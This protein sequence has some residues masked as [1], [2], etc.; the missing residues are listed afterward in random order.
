MDLFSIGKM[1]KKHKSYR[2]A[3]LITKI[4]FVMLFLCSTEVFAYSVDSQNATAAVIIKGTVRD[5]TGPLPGISVKVKGTSKIAVTDIDGKFSISAEPTETLAFTSVGYITK[6]VQNNNKTTINVFLEEDSQKLDELVVVGYGKQKKVSVTGAI[7]TIDKTQ[8]LQSPQANISNALVGRMPGLLSVQGSGQPGADGSTL[9]I[10]GIG[11]FSGNQDPLIMVDGIETDNYNNID[12]NEIESVSILKDASATAVYGVRGANGVLIITTRRGVEGKP[13]VSYSFQKAITN[14][15]ST[16]HNMMG[17]D[18]ARNYNEAQK[19]DGYRTGG[20]NPYFTPEAI[21]HYRVGDDPVFYPNVDWFPYMFDKTA[22]QNQHNFNINGGTERVKYFI[23]LGYFNQEGL[24]NH[25]DL[26]DGY[27]GNLKFERY[28]IRAN[29]DFKITKRLSASINL[30]SQIEERSGTSSSISTLFDATVAANPVF[31]P[32]II[33]GKFIRL[34]TPSS[35]NALGNLFNSGVGLQN[36]YK[37][38]LNSSVRLNYDLDFITK[39]LSTHATVSYNNTNNQDIL[40]R[41]DLVQYKAKRLQDQSVVYIPQSDPSPFGFSES[42]GKNRKEYVEIGLDYNRKFGEHSVSA[43]M[44]YNESKRYDPD[45]AFLVPNGYQGIVGRVTYDYK[46]KYLAEAN[47]GYNGT[48]NFA[49]GKR[50][51]LFPAFSLGWVVTEESFFPKNDIM[52]YM[53]IRGSYGVVGNDKIG[54]IKRTADRFL[55]RPAAYTYTDNFYQFGENGSNQTGYKG[56]LEGQL[57]NDNLIWERAAK[58]NIAVDFAFWKSKIKATVEVFKESRSNI[59][60]KRNTVSW[61]AGVPLPAYNLGIMDNKGLEAEISYNDKVGKFDYW[62]K[63]NFTFARNIIKFKDESPKAYS[64]KY[65]TGQASGQNFGL[66]ADGFFNTWEDVNDANRP[67]YTFQTNKIQPGDVRYVD[68]NGDGKIDGDDA[69]P[70]GYSSFPEK[71]FGFS[72]GGNYKGFDF[73]VLFQG[74]TNV[75]ISY[76]RNYT[77]PF[78][79]YRASRDYMVNS[80]SEE[81]Y[82][83]GLPIQFPHFNTGYVN[84]QTNYNNSTLWTQDAS[85]VR[86]KNAEI[87]YTIPRKVLSKIKITSLRFYANGNNLITWD[88]MLPGVDPESAAA[89]IANLDPYPLTRTINFGF[90]VKF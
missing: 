63:G 47:V 16:P 73:S 65:E 74:A 54:D 75:S 79:E 64:Y 53:K 82:N 35:P 27:D 43:M 49:P 13:Q 19:Y 38:Y 61:T 7:S 1:L 10:R 58:S 89:S 57:G 78:L 40:Y 39:G 62:I 68:V 87:G 76:S 71:T 37:N 70:I 32:L 83:Q 77:Q 90:N 59:L 20:Y 9:R 26:V 81:R 46:S 31:Q 85:Y 36:N 3:L 2:N 14:F 17:Y 88:K 51:G 69:V 34:D 55:Y 6:E 44:L 8:L 52:T 80:W 48:E 42:F 12:P 72:L 30:S 24:I 67:F 25:T 84:S 33:D 56:A 45:F 11:T 28:N 29:F 86:L 50:F 66:I 41:K 18:Y 15:T 22:G 23:S 21:E 4:S 5:K 60:A